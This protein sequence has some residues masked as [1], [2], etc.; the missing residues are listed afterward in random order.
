MCARNSF[1]SS[2]FFHVITP[3][4]T[5]R[6]G[7]CTQPSIFSTEKMGQILDECALFYSTSSFLLDI[8]LF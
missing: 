7:T 2:I 6:N 3:Y 4:C 1:H 5:V 8:L